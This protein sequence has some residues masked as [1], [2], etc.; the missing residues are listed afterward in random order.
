MAPATNPASSAYPAVSIVAAGWW[1]LADAATYYPE[2]LPAEW[3]LSYFANEHAGVYLPAAIWRTK[4]GETLATWRDDVPAGFRFF[5]EWPDGPATATESAAAALADKLAGWVCWSQGGLRGAVRD[6]AGNLRP[7]GVQA[8]WCP[9]DILG[10]L[11]SGARWLRDVAAA[12]PA[13]LVLMRKPSSTQLADWR[14]MQQLLGF[15]EPATRLAWA[16][17]A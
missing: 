4:T 11:R 10:D 17:P 5:L 14:H 13:T 9:P 16:P 1:D 7:S 12:A 6:A 3:Q 8:L 2:D 15:D